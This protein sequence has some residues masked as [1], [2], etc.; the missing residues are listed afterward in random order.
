MDNLDEYKRG[1]KVLRN[2][3]D[4]ARERSSDLRDSM[5]EHYEEDG[6]WL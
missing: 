5:R 1:P 4:F 3:Q 2:M 6:S